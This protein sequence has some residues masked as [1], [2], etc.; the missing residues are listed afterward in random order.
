ERCPIHDRPL[1]R[2]V[3]PQKLAWWYPEIGITPEG[4]DLAIKQAPQEDVPRNSWDAYVLGRMGVI[5]QIRVSSL[6]ESEM[7]EVIAAVELL[8]RAAIFHFGTVAPRTF[9]RIEEQ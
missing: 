5:P 2:G 1:E 8:G 4:S 9:H 7:F 3:G 6:D